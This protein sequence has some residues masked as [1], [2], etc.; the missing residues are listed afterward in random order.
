MDF[1]KLNNEFA[2]M[3]N[4]IV[5][6][7]NVVNEVNNRVK[8]NQKDINKLELKIKNTKDSLQKDLY[9]MY[10]DSIIRENTFIQGLIKCDD[11]NDKEK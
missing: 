9:K 5:K 3:Q 4:I 11:K 1:S 10:V 7:N 8:N 6:Y 2:N